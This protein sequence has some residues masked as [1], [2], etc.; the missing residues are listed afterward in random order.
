MLRS[1]H[2]GLA[3]QT[4][5]NYPDEDEIE[6]GEPSSHERALYERVNKPLSAPPP[7]TGTAIPIDAGTGAAAPAAE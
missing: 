7:A 2:E 5:T 3:Q 6:A 1:T 4:S